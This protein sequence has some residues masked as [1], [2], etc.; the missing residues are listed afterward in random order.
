MSGRVYSDDEFALILQRAAELQDRADG[1][2]ARLP[3]SADRASTTDGLS[4]EAVRDIAQEVGLEPRFV[5]QAAASLALDPAT[6]GLK[7]LGGPRSHH[8]SDTFARTLTAAQQ[9]ELLDVIRGAVRHSGEVREVM[10]SLEW[11]TV[12]RMSQTTVTINSDDDSVAVRVFNDLSGIAVLT[13]VPAIVIGLGVGGI[14][15]DTLQPSLL[16]T[17]SILGVAAAVGA[18]VARTIWSATTG[19][20]RGRTERLRDEI[21]RHLTR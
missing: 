13:W 8:V 15:V 9:V 1:A 16:V 12:G 14:V 17:V 3:D 19:F 21:A 2:A 10:G 11:R 6:K 4:L 5:D 18:G 7:L 20:F